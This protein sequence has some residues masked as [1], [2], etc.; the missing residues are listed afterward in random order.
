MLDR[1]RA[2][3]QVKLQAVARTLYAVQTSSNPDNTGK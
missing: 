2:V 1:R 3:K